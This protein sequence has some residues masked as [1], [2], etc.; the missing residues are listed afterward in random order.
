MEKAPTHNFQISISKE[1]LSRLPLASYNNGAQVIESEDGLDEAIDHLSQA[2]I[3][4][5][6]TETRPSFRKGTTYNVA[7]LQLAS[8]ERAYLFRLNKL[9]AH[10]RL[11]ELLENPALLK[12]GVSLHDDFHSLGRICDIKPQGF[13]DL[14]Q[15]VK[16]YSIADNSLA[17]IYGILFGQRISKGQRLTNW[18]ADKLTSAQINYAA[19]DAVACIQIYDYITRG[20]FR[21]EDSQYIK[22]VI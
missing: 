20:A 10:P 1:E 18:E 9:G 3:I 17:R 11:L 6:D 5:F 16:R 13:I 2:R 21:P 22:E 12:V 14:Q 19:F 15:Y 8:P 7:L 4:G